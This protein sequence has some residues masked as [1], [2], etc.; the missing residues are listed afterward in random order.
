MKK[1][2]KAGW[3]IAYVIMLLLSVLNCFGGYLISLDVTLD[4]FLYTMA[5]GTGGTDPQVIKEGA[6][7]IV[8]RVAAQAAV[9]ALFIGV[10]HVTRRKLDM[11]IWFGKKRRSFKPVMSR[12]LA[13]LMLC[14]CLWFCVVTYGYTLKLQ[15]LLLRGNKETSIYEEC[16]V[17]PAAVELTAPEEK[18]NLIFVWLE[19]METTYGEKYMPNMTRIA[20]E[21]THFS[22]ENGAESGMHSVQYSRWTFGALFTASSAT[23]YAYNANATKRWNASIAPN[24][25]FLWEVLKQNG[26]S[27]EYV[28][29]S[30]ANFATTDLIFMAHGIDEIYDWNT[31]Q[32]VDVPEGYRYGWGVE[33]YILYE[34]AEREILKQ[35]ESGEP[36]CVMLSTIDTHQ[37]GYLCSECGDEY[38]TNIEN[39]IACAD[40]QV[41]E[42][43]EWCKAQDFYENTVIALVGDHPRMD[44]QL[45]KG[46]DYYDRTLYHAIINPATEAVNTENR[47]VTL[48][49]M[50]P[51]VLGALGYSIEG[52]R[53]GFGTNL[54]SDRPTVYEEVGYEY[55]ESEIVK[56]SQ[57]FIENM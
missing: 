48:L 43:I 25:P 35:A 16:Y 47:I 23:P 37:P 2:A 3:I 19:S 54:F 42:F 7:Y 10:W 5:A 50:Y 11:V 26:Y 8:P 17:D 56:K 53:I 6:L 31:M 22:G 40:R 39:I 49:D 24:T 21:N 32:G 4:V 30:D 51:T 14:T 29:G 38:P 12:M 45:V 52:D 57:W 18:R 27:T 1:S 44:Q 9:W 33:D 20:W 34:V 15:D 28:L 46:V 55:F 41:N 36:F 13:G